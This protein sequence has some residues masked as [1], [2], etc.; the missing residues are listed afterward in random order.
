G[1]SFFVGVVA[2]TVYPTQR[3]IRPA[4]LTLDARYQATVDPLSNPSVKI[5]VLW[6][7]ASPKAPPLFDPAFSTV[8]ANT[9]RPPDRVRP[10]A[11]SRPL[12]VRS[13]STTTRPSLSKV[14]SRLPSGS[15]RT[16]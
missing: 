1:I 6:S 16:T 3:R 4:A 11:T 5:K 14:G 2:R 10:L 8:P 15:S 12:V 9:T 7:R 13:K